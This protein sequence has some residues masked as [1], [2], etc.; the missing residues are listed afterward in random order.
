MNVY[1]KFVCCLIV[2]SFVIF[3][4]ASHA[5][6]PLIQAFE[7]ASLLST[8]ADSLWKKP[9]D[10]HGVI[11]VP[12]LQQGFSDGWPVGNLG[13][14]GLD[15][16][17]VKGVDGGNCGY[18]ALKNV[19][20]LM[21]AFE[22]N[23]D[24]YVVALQSKQP[25]FDCMSVWGP[26]IYEA[27]GYDAHVSWLGGQ[28][29]DYLKNNL[30]P[31]L[32]IKALSSMNVHGRIVVTE[33]VRDVGKAVDLPVNET[34]LEPIKELAQ[35]LNGM[36]GVVWT[37]GHGGH[38]VGFVVY[39]RNGI[40]KIFYMNSARGIHPNFKQVIELF[41]MTV[42]DI[43]TII[44]QNQTKNILQDF[45]QMQNSCDVLSGNHSKDL[46]IYPNFV[47]CVLR[48][49]SMLDN[50]TREQL[51]QAGIDADIA[52]SYL[53]S[54]NL[55]WQS[56][57]ER[58]IALKN[59]Q[60]RQAYI[61]RI[62]TDE[63]RVYGFWYKPDLFFVC[64]LGVKNCGI[65]QEKYK[66]SM[67]ILNSHN[68]TSFFDPVEKIH[69]VFNYILVAWQNYDQAAFNNDLQRQMVNVMENILIYL[70]THR[71]VY[72]AINWK[73]FGEGNVRKFNGFKEVMEAVIKRLTHI[74]QIKKQSLRDK[75]VKL[76]IV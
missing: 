53:E 58:E 61:N 73:E 27:R 6:A 52:G 7:L 39:K 3:A 23:D 31:L 17:D 2:S 60:F 19:L 55:V 45:A 14:L 24:T 63:L 10:T 33:D 32:K 43:D 15:W 37:A 1:Q 40:Q 26:M 69:A 25:F 68:E 16:S 38:W 59:E 75:Y 36:L 35:K 46:E 62:S 42:G 28:E 34:M 12:V 20:F 54:V 44:V 4:N 57:L 30:N 9:F 5:N 67:L 41:S 76:L 51:I 71:H 48:K 50:F 74:S 13:D 47:G 21:N 64:H 70:D 22:N 11:E 18:H 8:K 66:N 56:Y 49:G 72:R 65:A 29:I